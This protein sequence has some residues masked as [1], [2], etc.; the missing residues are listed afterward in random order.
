MA[1]PGLVRAKLRHSVFVVKCQNESTS[2]GSIHQFCENRENLLKCWV[3]IL[4]KLVNVERVICMQI[5]A[6]I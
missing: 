3:E 2:C 1:V 6:S 5:K 4:R